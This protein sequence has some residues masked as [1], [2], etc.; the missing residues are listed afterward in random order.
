MARNGFIG[1]LDECRSHIAQEHPQGTARVL[2]VLKDDPNPPP[3]QLLRQEPKPPAKP[4]PR[5]KPRAKPT[6]TDD[7]NDGPWETIDRLAAI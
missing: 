1:S 4:K 3:P 5:A 2:P 6:A 7:D